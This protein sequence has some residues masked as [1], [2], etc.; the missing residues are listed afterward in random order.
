MS[1]RT[2][3][4]GEPPVG[5][6]RW[7]GQVK[8]T[9]RAFL[10]YLQIRSQLF[11][12]ECRE[13]AT[14]GGRQLM[15]SLVAGA[16]LLIGYVLLTVCLIVLIATALRVF[17]IW[18]ALFFALAHLAGGSG[19]W[20]YAQTRLKKPLFEATLSELE[21]DQEWITRNLPSYPE[22]RS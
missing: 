18:P 13:A 6:A 10:A 4:E 11:A 21:K 1:S 14:L 17:W 3:L 9:A 19:V 8:A 15:V 22:R 2:R 12:L 7:A 16:M 20:W 5:T